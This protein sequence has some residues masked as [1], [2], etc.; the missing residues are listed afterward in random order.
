MNARGGGDADSWGYRLLGQLRYANVFGA[1]N[2]APRLA[3]SHDVKGYTPAPFSAFW[4]GRK[5]VSVGLG[6][7]YINRLT[8]DLSYTAFFGG[9]SDNPLQD[10]D[11][12]RFNIT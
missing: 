1:V 10:R 12:I 7:D 4:E 3:F 2:L 9:G 11:F 6:C 8:A 5:A